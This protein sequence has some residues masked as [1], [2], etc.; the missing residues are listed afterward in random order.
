MVEN[1]GSKTFTQ[2][3][4]SLKNGM[5][6]NKAIEQNLDI[7][8][9]INK[10]DLPSSNPESVEKQI[11]EIIGIDTKNSKKVSAKTGEGV[12]ELLESIVEEIPWAG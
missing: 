4:K 12:N 2:F 6:V 8:T 7:L 5:S 10:I 3:I 9:V 1:F 11:N